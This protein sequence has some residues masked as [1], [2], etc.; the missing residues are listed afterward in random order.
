MA[1]RRPC[2]FCISIL[3]SSTHLADQNN[4]NKN[5]TEETEKRAGKF[6]K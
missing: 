2:C 4:S 6:K 1:A 3:K 5:A